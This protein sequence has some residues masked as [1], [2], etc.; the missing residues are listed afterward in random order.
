M[1]RFVIAG[2]SGFLGVSLARH[3]AHA[4]HEVVVLS[5]RGVSVPGA[6][7]ERWDGRSVGPW[8]RRLDGADGLVNLAGRSVNC[9]KTPDHRDEILRSR[10]ASTLALGAA[11][12][13]LQRPPPIWAQMSTAHI[14]GDPPS[15]RCDEHSPTGLGLAPDV[16]RAWEAALE[17]ACA[18]LPGGGPRRV[19]LRTGF[20]IGRPNPGGAGALGTLGALARF[21]LGGRVA[22][23]SQGMSWIHEVDLNRLFERALTDPSMQG[24]YVASA[25]T[26][27]G[28]AE[29]MRELRRV[30]GGVGRWLALPASSW[31]VR[32]GAG[33]V[34]RTDPELA[35]YGRYVVSARLDAEG[36]R[37]RFPALRAALEDLHAT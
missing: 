23:G 36:F 32:L 31:M 22:S 33:L 16:G 5:R 26:P 29:F 14:Y 25:P 13:G 9:V 28:Q 1:G 20:V 21:G 11:M 30:A 3:L 17:Q 27:V 8:A 37:F 7:S 34:L 35:L 18:A 6:A 2:G 19:V 4:G 15:D 10:V 12:A 24:V